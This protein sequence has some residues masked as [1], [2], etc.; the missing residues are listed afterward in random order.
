M[1]RWL[2]EALLWMNFQGTSNFWSL[3]LHSKL[4]T[5]FF[6]SGQQSAASPG[7]LGCPR[8]APGPELRWC[9][10]WRWQN[11]LRYLCS[12]NKWFADAVQSGAAHGEV[13]L[14]ECKFLSSLGCLSI[15]SH[16]DSRDGQCA[17]RNAPSVCTLNCKNASTWS[18][19][20]GLASQ[21]LVQSIYS[22]TYIQYSLSGPCIKLLCRMETPLYCA[23]TCFGNS[24][25]R[26]WALVGQ[27]SCCPQVWIQSTH[28]LFLVSFYSSLLICQTPTA[29]SVTV[30]Q[31]LFC[32][33]VDGV[34][35]VFDPLSLS[36]ISSLP[37]PHPLGVDVASIMDTRWVTCSTEPGILKSDIK[38]LPAIVH[39]IILSMKCEASYVHI[40]LLASSASIS[41]F[42]FFLFLLQCLAWVNWWEVQV[43]I[44]RRWCADSRLSKQS[45]MFELVSVC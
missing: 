32:G 17:H 33:C 7:P 22:F 44:S 45:C 2:L 14:I 8:W 39:W 1:C 42:F 37:N 15:C 4:C 19:E 3:L 10:M 28:L 43:D 21:F 31:H 40:L 13:C 23:G 27:N 41:F 34:V 9:C 18:P 30:G 5:I 38:N 25:L 36:Y 11:F 35:R 26:W 20:Y 6:A 24:G 16:G 12:D 29:L